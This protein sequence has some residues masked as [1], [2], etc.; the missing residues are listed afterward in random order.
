MTAILYSVCGLLLLSAVALIASYYLGTYVFSHRGLDA[1]PCINNRE[2]TVRMQRRP[3]AQSFCFLVVG[4]IQAGYRILS[5][6]VLPAGGDEYAFVVQ[7]G[8]LASHADRGHY[9]LVLNEIRRCNLSVP[10]FVIPG[11]HDRKDNPDLFERYF[12]L[13][14]FY[15]VWSDCLFV[16]FDNSLGA[17]YEQQ[18][19][20]L[21]QTLEENQGKARRTF[22]FMHR[23]PVDWDNGTPRPELKKHA[24]FF[25]LKQRFRIDYVISGHIHDYH[26]AELDGTTYISNGLESDQKGRAAD[27]IYLTRVQVTPEQVVPEKLAIPT[28][29]ADRVF[30]AVI[31]SLVAHLYYPLRGRFFYSAAEK[32][33]PAALR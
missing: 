3:A 27:E 21:E 20:F 10:L 8:D 33:P 22:I 25:A 6:G 17:S 24:R 29:V 7:T 26:V 12:K 30:G 5:R 32:H 19:Q 1:I 14:Q 23:P 18:F 16:F 28:S 4:D 31:D 13:K 11:N 2:N 15:F 9:A